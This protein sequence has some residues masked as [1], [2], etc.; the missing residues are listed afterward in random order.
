MPVDFWEKSKST[1]I[2]RFL[3]QVRRIFAGFEQM[4]MMKWT[5]TTWRQQAAKYWTKA[6]FRDAILQWSCHGH[7]FNEQTPVGKNYRVRQQPIVLLSDCKPKFMPVMLLTSIQLNQSVLLFV[8][9]FFWAIVRNVLRF[10]MGMF[11]GQ[12]TK[13]TSKN[14]ALPSFCL[15]QI[16]VKWLCVD[17]SHILLFIWNNQD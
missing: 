5:R 4:W 7:C 15:R 2:K 14:Q 9:R 11:P 17:I 12:S 3:Q 13:P 10:F 6:Q 8:R 16:K 1:R